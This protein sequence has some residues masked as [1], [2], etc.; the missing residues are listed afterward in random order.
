M[1]GGKPAD[2]ILII[3]LIT[4]KTKKLTPEE[5]LNII[6]QGEN[7]TVEFKTSFGKEVIETICAF[8]N[9]KG[10]KVILGISDSGV[11]KGIRTNFESVQNW[12]NEIKQKTE[13]ALLPDANVEVIEDKTIVIISVNEFPIKPISVKG[14]YFKRIRNSNHQLSA[15]EISE[16]TMQSLHL[17]WDSYP[18]INKDI[19]DID[20]AK[21]SLFIDKVNIA[22]RFSLDNDA[23]KSLEKLKL[24][25]DEKI[26]NACYLLFGKDETDYNIHLGRFKT[27]SLIIDDK[28]VR[29]TLLEAVEIL[30]KYLISQIKVAF[31]ITGETSQRNEI[32]EYPLPALRELVIN[33]IVHRDY[34][35][36]S[37]IQIK[38]YDQSIT[39]FNPGKLFGGITIDDLKTDHYQS[40]TRNKLIAECFYLTKDIEKYGS[41]YIRVREA[42]KEYPTML[43][44]Y[45]ETGDGFLASLS[46][47]KQRI[48]SGI[49]SKGGLNEGLNEG[50]N[51]LLEVIRMNPGIQAK[52]LPGFLNM[53]PLKT[54][55]RQLSQLIK[56]K[57]I[58]RKGSRKTG[59]YYVLNRNI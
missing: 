24:I 27:E 20:L 39:I 3:S 35:N 46:Y 52:D 57:L 7:E 45:K 58:E 38:I 10:G 22:G 30:M 40:R 34:A 21:V 2:T 5:L 16:L 36:P 53:R 32:F 23:I 17:S 54:I 31:E 1:A 14:R 19:E 25:K 6:R 26:T 41:G 18:A 15:I 12:L 28:I 8:A 48:G 50:L 55:E 13:P 44:E 59:G 33:A 29:A 43:F 42:I 49:V 11:I 51:T 9:N 4:T 37:D 56:M 47:K